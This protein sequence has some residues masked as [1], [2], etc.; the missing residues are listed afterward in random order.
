MTTLLERAAVQPAA[1]T[2]TTDRLRGA[3]RWAPAVLAVAGLALWLHSAGT[4]VRDIASFGAYLALGITIPGALWWRAIRRGSHTVAEDFAVGTALGYAL[5]VLAYIPARA[6][7]APLAVLAWPIATYLLFALVPGLRAVW[8]M[9]PA[10]HLPV[11][12]AWTVT[13]LA[14]Y[15]AIWAG[16]P[17]FRTHGLTYPASASPYID[18]PYYLS[19]IG[20]VRNHVP[21]QFPFEA[22]QPLTHHWLLHAE[23]A[24]TSWVTGIEPQTLL[25]RLSALPM[26]VVFGVILALLAR[27][28]VG[29]WWAGAATLGATWALLGPAPVP[30][31]GRLA[32]AGGFQGTL[33]LCPTQT[34]GALL[35][36]GVMTFVVVMLTRSDG[37]RIGQ[38]LGLAAVTAVAMG[39][40][41]TFGVLLVA[42]LGTALLLGLLLHRAF[43]GGLLVLLAGALAMLGLSRE[44]VFGGESFGLQLLYPSPRLTAVLARVG[45]DHPPQWMFAV[46]VGMTLVGWLCVAAPAL[47]M[48]RDQ[49]RQPVPGVLLGAVGAALVGGIVLAHP[50]YS[51]IYFINSAWPYLCLLAVLGLA[52]ALRRRDGRLW[53]YAAAAGAGALLSYLAVTFGMRT[54]PVTRVD[55]GML[56]AAVALVVPWALIVVAGVAIALVL[57]RRVV[58]RRTRLFATLLALVLAG[59]AIQTSVAALRLPVEP[60]PAAQAIPA[61][62]AEA[63]R[64]L[65]DHSSPDDLVAT[66]GHCWPAAKGCDSRHFWVSGYAERRVLVESWAYTAWAHAAWIPFKLHPSRV[67]YHDPAKLA[68]NDEVF[69]RPSAAAVTRLRD[70]YGVK[71]LFVDGGQN[72]PAPGLADVAILR[73]AAGSCAVYE[74]PAA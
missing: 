53:Q 35:F 56:R 25:F 73:F 20:E 46:L 59:F 37:H 4:P 68:A 60:A 38:W 23:M 18:I 47:L 71:W 14:C 51:E 64:W 34:F 26:I 66:N 12:F 31:A 61:G 41:G 32:P 10:T 15:P 36:A 70:A 55:H 19:L 72:P 22:G 29:A 7:G 44:L 2:R 62:A 45:L 3:A 33:W 69:A 16:V 43:H 65:R 13:V 24:A 54:P 1:S 50:A 58:E 52:V 5:E 27:R 30:W 48:G 42:G 11:W 28:I 49:L 6:A 74:L 40:K 63:G 17:F 67:P 57:A 8:R 39:A 21:A 9:R